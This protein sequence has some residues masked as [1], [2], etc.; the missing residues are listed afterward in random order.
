[1][2]KPPAARCAPARRLGGIFAAE[3]DAIRSCEELREHRGIPKSLYLLSARMPIPRRARPVP[4]RSSEIGSSGGVAPPQP[5]PT[6]ATPT[7]TTAIF[8][9][10]RSNRPRMAYL[11]LQ[12]P[13]R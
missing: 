9:R 10:G 11:R 8:R 2:S 7:P 3:A 13:K 12:N 4:E 1:M 6:G 5:T